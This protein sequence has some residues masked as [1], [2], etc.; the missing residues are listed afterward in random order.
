[1]SLITESSF[2]W[3][4]DSRNMWINF[5]EFLQGTD[6]ENVDGNIYETDHNDSHRMATIEILVVARWL[7]NVAGTTFLLNGAANYDEMHFKAP[8]IF[9]PERYLKDVKN[10]LP[11]YAYG[12]GSRTCIGSHLTLPRKMDLSLSGEYYCGVD[13][14]VLQ[15]RSSNQAPTPTKQT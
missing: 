14:F 11:H 2:S 1:M 13:G 4:T 8:N 12:A 5:R 7:K 9:I 3:I 6:D 15:T 10:G